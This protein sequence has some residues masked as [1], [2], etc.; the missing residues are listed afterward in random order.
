M[1]LF[2]LRG[3]KHKLI[4]FIIE[5]DRSENGYTMNGF[6]HSRTI[7]L[8]NALGQLHSDNFFG[9]DCLATPIAAERSER[10]TILRISFE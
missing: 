4:L 8:S 6:S 1:T 9:E 5:L 2:L 10:E 7:F 3:L